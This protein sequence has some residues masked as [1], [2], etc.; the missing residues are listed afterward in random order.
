M[1]SSPRSRG[2]VDP[3]A[4]VDDDLDALAADRRLELVAVPRAMIRPWSTTAISSASS[5]ASSRYCV[6]RSSVVPSAHERG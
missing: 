6:V 5:S 1:P 4:V 3:G 2:V